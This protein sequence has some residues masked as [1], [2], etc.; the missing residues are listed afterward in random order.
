MG[1]AYIR[2]AL[3]HPAHYR[4]MFGGFAHLIECDPGLQADAEKSFQV[5][6]Q[7]LATLQAAKIVRRDDL[8]VQARYVWAIVHGIATLAMDGQLGPPDKATLEPLIQ[9]ALRR[10]QTGIAVARTSM[11]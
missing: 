9:L 6:V 1:Q 2:F 3:E 7:A 11:R 5:L 10:M 4:V 8:V